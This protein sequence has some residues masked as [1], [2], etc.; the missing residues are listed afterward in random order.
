MHTCVDFGN[1]FSNKKQ[2]T[3]FY[4]ILINNREESIYG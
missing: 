2:I 4:A 3:N 1:V